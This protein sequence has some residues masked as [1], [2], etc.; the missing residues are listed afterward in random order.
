VLILIGLRAS[1]KTTIGK[2]LAAMTGRPFTDLD[3][4]TA[5]R[6]NAPNAS[7]G[8]R[9]HGLQAFREAELESLRAFLPTAKPD[10]ILA[11]GGGT[12]TIPQA[13][14]LLRGA[15]AQIIYLRATAPTLRARLLTDLK[16]RPSITGD[17]PIAEVDALLAQ[18]DSTYRGLAQHVIETDRLAESQVI[19][20][21]RRVVE[22]KH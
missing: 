22:S 13:A 8:L 1:G 21:L 2:A 7:E 6:L 3:D 5:Q 20:A 15:P 19:H 4:L 14:A 12:P 11:L 18:R 9:T 17:G 16:T 10:H